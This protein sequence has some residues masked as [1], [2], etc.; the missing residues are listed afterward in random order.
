MTRAIDRDEDDFE[1]P[2]YRSQITNGSGVNHIDPRMMEPFMRNDL[3]VRSKWITDVDKNR[4]V[5]EID[6]AI[7]ALVPSKVYCDGK[8]NH[9]EAK[10]FEAK[11]YA[12]LEG[13]LTAVL[14]S[15]ATYSAYVASQAK[16]GT[17]PAFL[18][19][20]LGVA[21]IGTLIMSI[22][23]V[24]K[25]GE[26]SRQIDGWK[27]SPIEKLAQERAK[28]YEKG[29]IYAK[30]KEL[31]LYADKL[32]MGGP[33]SNKAVL[34]PSEVYFLFTRYV[35][36]FG[37]RLLRNSHPT[38][39]HGKKVWLDSFTTNNPVSKSILD[40]AHI[41]YFTEVPEKYLRVSYD[42]DVLHAQLSELRS[43]FS[44]LRK[45]RK[46]ETQAIV[47]GINSNR[48]LALLPFQGMHEY[49]L[50]QA[51]KERDDKLL[52]PNLSREQVKVIHDKYAAEKAR[53]DNLLAVASIPVN[54]YYD[55]QILSAKKTLKGILEQIDRNE[56]SS[57]APFY[58]YARS[59]LEFAMRAKNEPDIVY[60]P[61]NFRPEQIF[62]VPVPSAPPLAAVD[63]V[64]QARQQIPKGLDQA[65]YVEYTRFISYT[66]Q[67]NS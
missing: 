9:W 27:Q 20:V 57:H 64:E 53:C 30:E 39:E 51:K 44:K 33:S 18:A 67:Q 60:V 31:K 29:F 8:I 47:D 36:S 4:S 52:T 40:Y 25:A 55:N 65:Q 63:F 62:N 10:R 23:N 1:N 14:A 66:P 59:M 24:S 41:G 50:G 58:N 61:L 16:N 11:K 17:N 35:D 21:S 5:Y 12:W 6:T 45:Q 2:L 48:T 43:D 28:A 38:T 56:A 46:D 22:N 49:W 32:N 15:V 7:Q 34:V 54:L 3:S 26:A 42:F 37:D 13:G 19:A